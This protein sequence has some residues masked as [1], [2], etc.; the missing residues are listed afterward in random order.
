L[1]AT[2]SRG[3]PRLGPEVLHAVGI[4][5]LHAGKGLGELRAGHPVDDHRKAAEAILKAERDRVP[6]PQLSKT[7]PG[8][9]IARA[10]P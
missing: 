10:R 3:D 8:M 5:D 1:P 2:R 7:F 9:E 6:C 4:R